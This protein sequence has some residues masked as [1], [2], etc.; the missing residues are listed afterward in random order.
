M[1]ISREKCV[2]SCLS[3][4][5]MLMSAFAVAIPRVRADTNLI[6]NGDFS[7][8]LADWTTVKVV[9][10][11]GVRGEYPIFEV[12]TQNTP[13]QCTPSGRLGNPFLNI[14]VPFGADGYVEQ[15][16]TI[17]T[18]G[19]QLSFVSWGWEN[20]DPQFSISG[21][22][23]AY[24]R[25]I[26]ATG[27]H[28]L[29]TYTPP[30]MLN[31][32]D[33]NNPNDDT[34]TGNS[35][36]SKTYDLSAYSGETVKL[37]L[38]ATSQNCCGTLA[39]FDDVTVETH[40][41]PLLIDHY[42]NVLNGNTII[43]QT[44]HC[45]PLLGQRYQLVL[46]IQNPDSVRHT[47]DI[48]VEQDSASPTVGAPGWPDWLG[49]IGLPSQ[50]PANPT[51]VGTLASF[52]GALCGSLPQQV[53]LGPGA[54]ANVI[55]TFT[56]KWNW[57]PEF[58]WKILAAQVI[59]AYVIAPTKLADL[60]QT[61]ADAD[62]A[63]PGLLDI[64]GDKYFILHEQ[65]HFKVLS[66][67]TVF[68]SFDQTVGVPN[69]KKVGYMSSF[70]FSLGAGIATA[71]CIS[72]PPS[73]LLALPIQA[74]LIA[75]QSYVYIAAHDPA[76][77][78][79]TSVVIPSP[80]TLNNGTMFLN[81][82]AVSSVSSQWKAPL[83]SL[84]RAVSFQN[85]TTISAARYSG[86]QDVGSQDF[87]NLQL[88]A[89][90]K[91][92][93]ARDEEMTAFETQL[94]SVSS[95][96]PALNSSNIQ[97]VHD[98]LAQNGLPSIEREI[99]SGLG[100]SQSID[101]ITS[102]MMAFNETSLNPTNI[103]TLSL[104]HSVQAA[105]QLL[106]GETNS[107]DKQ[108]TSPGEGVSV[109]GFYS[110]GNG[111][112]LPTDAQGN[113]EVNVVLAN[114]LVRSTNPGQVLAWVNVT[115][116]SGSSLQSLKLNETLPMDWVISPPWMPAKGAI[117]V[118]FANTTSLVTIP[119]ITQP[120]T[121]TVSTGNPQIVHLAIPSFNASAMGHPL[122]PG[123]TL[124]LS[125][126]TNYLP[127]G[128]SQAFK[129]YPRDYPDIMSTAAWVQPSYRGSEALAT[130]SA[131]FK[132]YAKVV[133]DVDGDGSVD[134]TDLVLVWQHQFTNDPRYDVNGD[135]ALDLND[136]VLTW[137]FQFT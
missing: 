108:A 64:I 70:I 23:N 73:C 126:K 9:T 45:E 21:L 85:A 37:R 123:Q 6:Q 121:I 74:V 122:M 62:I 106:I 110:D 46:L 65:F 82:P 131:F 92:S 125:I 71:G 90:A 52:P 36:V 72:F 4:T 113:P 27:D 129:S 7:N 109:S 15:Q 8:G 89:I 127:R 105:G 28:T 116:T 58:D 53:T 47:Y 128:T 5:L 17:P 107:W 114:G 135:G 112:Q 39:L 67:N 99:L 54:Y 26:D 117:H 56:N 22:V 31:P 44:P 83:E 32:G 111:N 86:A 20:N 75:Q 98:Y 120:S 80:L 68:G 91:Y 134:I 34:C 100:L 60:G 30:P 18:S 59:L 132:A 49:W 137:Q 96:V 130:S 13:V 61:A 55:F 35:P 102:G 12:L 2:I 97:L 94:S 81:L 63:F 42:F 78:N 16:V 33:P 66:G 103:S 69:V 25:I 57:I 14:E 93:A 118:F 136:L 119:E 10:S 3:I 43:C 76:D 19:A 88:Q 101:S 77:S 1:T 104:S 115:N 95:Q 11:N 40:N 38:G 51:C 79:Y 84:A 24:V 87:A 29:E 50:W 41:V 124:L 48:S 133:G